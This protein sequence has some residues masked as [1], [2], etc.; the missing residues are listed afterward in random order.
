MAV[1]Y[2]ATPLLGA[3]PLVWKLRRGGLAQPAIVGPAFLA[4]AIAVSIWQVRGS[5]FSIRW[6]PSRCA[7]W[8]G[9]WRARVRQQAAR[10]RR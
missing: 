6:P 1:S 2:Y 10:Q 3:A 5:T 9:E 4:A 8:V 7:A